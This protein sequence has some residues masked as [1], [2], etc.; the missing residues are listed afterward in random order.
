MVRWIPNSLMRGGYAVRRWW[1]SVRRDLCKNAALYFYVL[2]GFIVILLFNYLPMYGLQIA[3]RDFRP[4]AGIT[5]STFV[6]FK[7]FAR[8][9]QSYQWRQLVSNTLLLSLESIL[10]G[11]PFPIL[12]A[13]IFSQLR[14]KRFQRVAQTVTYMPHFISTVVMVGIILMFLSPNDGLY[15]NLVRLTGKEPQ[16]LVGYPANF[17]PIYILSDIWQHS[18]W[19]SII[20]MAALSAID[21]Q[22]YDAAKV[23]GASKLQRIWY[24]DIACILPTITILLILRLGNVMSVGFEKAYLMQNTQNLTAS[25]VIPTYVY[26]V[27]LVNMKYSYSAA[28]GMMNMAINCFLL[29]T[30]NTVAKRLDGTSLW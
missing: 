3:L 2:P 9:F 8:F 19:D 24:I 13:I 12:M 20:Y 21:T 17:R 25:E 29:V 11:F 26:K 18:G 16:N 5:G 15:G 4:A 28:I 23:D 30:V 7:H 10:F 14:S 6:G 22:L 1:L 27:G